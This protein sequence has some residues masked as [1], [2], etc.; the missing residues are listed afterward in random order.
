MADPQVVLSPLNRPVR[1]G[2]FGNRF[3]R[4]VI[5]PC[6][7]QVEG[8]EVVGLSSPNQQ[9]AQETA[10][11]FDIPCVT[12]DHRELLRQTAPDL[13]FIATPPALHAS[14]AIDALRAGAHVVC[15]KPMALNVQECRQMLAVAQ[16]CGRLAL[17]DHEL[18][19]LPH[20]RTLRR[21]LHEGAIGRPLRASYTILSTTRRSA[22]MPWTWWADAAQGGGAWTTLGAHAVDALC[23]LLGPPQDAA[24]GRVAR[25][26]DQLLDPSSGVMRAV[27][28]DEYAVAALPFAAPT[29]FGAPTPSVEA[30]IL[31]SM[32]EPRGWHEIF[33]TGEKGSLRLAEQGPLELWD[34]ERWAIVDVQDD[35]PSS[36]SLGIPDMYWARGFLHFAR[37]LVGAIGRGEVPHTAA[38]FSD[39][40]RTQEI[41]DQARLDGRL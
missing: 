10:H 19:F 41:L 9:R 31:V 33:I 28:A 39:G 30:N 22:D 3:A 13:V 36:A 34:G 7:R 12:P 21:M 40:L 4:D 25:F 15:E 8:V 17:I 5:L 18:R 35:L 11:E 37:H 23:W 27:T 32:V 24:H 2:V 14:M 20:R 6:L 29:Q 38:T 16:E 26:H 1:V